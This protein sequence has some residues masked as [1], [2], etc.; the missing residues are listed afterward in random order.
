MDQQHHNSWQEVETASL[1]PK[2]AKEIQHAAT[3][4][5]QILMQH[6]E[7]PDLLNHSLVHKLL[8]P[9]PQGTLTGGKDGPEHH[10]DRAP[11]HPGHLLEMVPEEGMLIPKDSLSISHQTAEHLN[12]TDYLL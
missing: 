2:A 4:P 8:R 5:L 1:H 3:A 6:R 11:T 7:R 10:W 12:W 9:R